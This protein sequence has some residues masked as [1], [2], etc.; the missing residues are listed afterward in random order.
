MED[1][2][3]EE[4]QNYAAINGIRIETLGIRSKT[5]GFRIRRISLHVYTEN[6]AV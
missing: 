2:G 1:E 6:L 3:E 4:K 5:K